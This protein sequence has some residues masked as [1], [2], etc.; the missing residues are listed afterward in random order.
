M[1]DNPLNSGTKG[2]DGSFCYLRVHGNEARSSLNSARFL[3]VFVV[4]LA[5]SIMSRLNCRNSPLPRKR[6]GESVILKHEG[7]IADVG[8]EEGDEFMHGAVVNARAV[9]HFAGK[10][11]FAALCQFTPNM[12]VS[13]TPV[14]PRAR[15]AAILGDF[16]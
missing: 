10:A 4:S 9:L 6:K 8:Y 11:V 16:E 13:R 14:A 15:I 12:G 2:R 1:A 5:I 7:Y 3:P